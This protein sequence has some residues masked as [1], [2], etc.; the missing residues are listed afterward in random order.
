MLNTLLNASAH[1]LYKSRRL[2]LEISV[3]IGC[4]VA[5]LKKKIFHPAIGHQSAFP[6]LEITQHSIKV[7]LGVRVNRQLT[8]KHRCLA[9]PIHTVNTILAVGQAIPRI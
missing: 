9:Q 4:L 1:L 2:S 5:I 6:N 7:S 8:T 3:W